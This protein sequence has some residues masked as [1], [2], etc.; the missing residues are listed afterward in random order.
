[1]KNLPQHVVHGGLSPLQHT[2][3]A[4]KLLAT[5]AIDSTGN[6]QL[7]GLTRPMPELL[8]IALLYHDI[9]KLEDPFSSDHPARSAELARQILSD[10]ELSGVGPLNENELSLVLLLIRTHDLLGEL[11]KLSSAGEVDQAGML[12]LIECELNPDQSASAQLPK[13]FQLHCRISL[14]DIRSIPGLKK[15][16]WAATQLSTSLLESLPQE[17]PTAG[18]LE[19][20]FRPPIKART[21][22]SMLSNDMRRLNRFLPSLLSKVQQAV[23]Q[24][25]LTFSNDY[26]SFNNG[27][28]KI[29]YEDGRFIARSFLRAGISELVLTEFLDRQMISSLKEILEAASL[30]QVSSLLPAELTKSPAVAG[31]RKLSSEETT[32]KTIPGSYKHYTNENNFI[33]IINNDLIEARPHQKNGEVRCGAYL[34]GLSLTPEEA[35]KTL[36]IAD[37]DYRDCGYFVIAFDVLDPQLAARISRNGI[38]LFLEEGIRLGDPQISV[39]YQGPNFLIEDVAA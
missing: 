7:P 1:M 31:L 13:L 23:F 6:L 14:A 36:F 17:Q 11:T 24:V 12:D 2:Y 39:R 5:D 3:N 37:P 35:F 8:R 32:V 29:D 27:I 19:A 18:S 16:V 30:G 26:L 4:L 20:D 21:G 9:G 10:P 15:Q 33:N 22:P 38:E 28:N 25:S 34:T